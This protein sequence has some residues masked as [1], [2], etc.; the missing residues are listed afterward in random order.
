[1]ENRCTLRFEQ[2]GQSYY[3]KLHQPL[4]FREICRSLLRGGLPVLSARDEW[5]A[6]ERLRRLGLDVPETAACGQYG[7]YP[8]GIH[9]FII[10]RALENTVSLEDYTA[11]WKRH[12][13]PGPVRRALLKQV[14]LIAR[15]MHDGGINHRDFYLCHFHLDQSRPPT[16]KP[17]L[18]LMDL[19]RAQLRPRTP[20]RWIVKDLGGIYFSALHIGLSR[21]DLLHFVS[22]YSGLPP[23]QALRRQERLWRQVQRRAA[24]L[25]REAVRKGQLP[26][27]GS[28]P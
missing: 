9:S 2:N 13:P 16:P 5:R 8:A 7:N 26:A 11:D 23:G 1:M 27:G 12:P 6:L 19:H 21:S 15:I 28:P 18:Y 4:R 14:A 10:T 3:L 20:L 17:R 22:T 24:A 25:R